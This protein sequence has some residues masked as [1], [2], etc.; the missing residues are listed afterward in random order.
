MNRSLA[1][2]A[3]AFVAAS[4]ATAQK[5][6]TISTF[7]F[8]AQGSLDADIGTAVIGQ[9][10][11][12]PKNAFKLVSFSFYIGGGDNGD[13]LNFAFRLSRWLPP[14]SE[15]NP[16]GVEDI[17]GQPLL[18]QHPVLR[19]TADPTRFDFRGLYLR[20]TP[21][22][23]YVAWVGHAGPGGFDPFVTLGMPI[24][25][26]SYSGGGAFVDGAIQP[27]LGTD[28]DL[29][30]EAVF[31][32]TPEPSTW[33]LLGSGLVGIGAVVVRSRRRKDQDAN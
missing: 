14:F 25:G 8:P 1:V 24:G 29:M 28:A 2:F 11:T 15:E 23:Q 26:D 13:L 6:Q 12:A 22:K 30:F 19:G 9:V 10:F 32:V 33:V 31:T 21:L 5:T 16:N 17:H 4:S 27:V 3:F 18:Y 7:G 20:V